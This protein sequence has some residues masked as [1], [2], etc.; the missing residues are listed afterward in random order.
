MYYAIFLM[1]INLFLDPVLA[2]YV[3][4]KLAFS[5]NRGSN[6]YW[7]SNTGTFLFI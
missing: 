1:P 2:V 3:K 7:L 5:K 4:K 6:M